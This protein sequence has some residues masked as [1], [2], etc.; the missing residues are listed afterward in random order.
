MPQTITYV[1]YQA[2]SSN[3]MPVNLSPAFMFPVA[4]PAYQ[5]LSWQLVVQD[6]G[7]AIWWGGINADGTLAQ[8]QAPSDFTY[9]GSASCNANLQIQIIANPMPDTKCPCDGSDASGQNSCSA[10]PSSANSV[11]LATGNFIFQKS[12]LS[13][14]G[15]GSLGWSFDLNYKSNFDID[16]LVGKNFAYPQYMHLEFVG[17]ANDSVNQ[18]NVQLVTDQLS[19]A[20]FFN[21]GE[22]NF[23]AQAGSNSSQCSLKVVNQFTAE[24]EYILTASN[25]TVTTFYGFNYYNYLGEEYNY[26]NP[27][28]GQIKSI[29]DRN[30]N[31]MMYAWTNSSSYIDEFGEIVYDGIPLLVSVTDSYGRAI[32]YS[33]YGD[34]GGYLLQQIT[35]YLGRQLNFQYDND[36]RLIAV[37]TPAI[38]RA[39]PGNTFPGG[40]AYV[41]QYDSGNANSAR[42]DD[43]IKIWYPNQTQPYLNIQTRTV[44]VES[45]YTNATPRY[46][47]TY[48]QDI[49]DLDTYGKVLTETLGDP[50][51]GIGGTAAFEYTTCA[52][53]LP[54]NIID[55]SSAGT[56]V[57]RTIHTDRNGNRTIYDF[58]AGWTVSRLEVD[59]NRS[60]S[61]LELSN[62]G[63]VAP[64]PFVTWTKFNSQNQPLVVVYPEGNSVEYTYDGGIIDGLPSP[65]TPMVGLLLKE[66]RLP[67]NSISLP[68]RSGSNGQTMLSK[69]YFYDPIFNR[70]CAMIEERGN[71]IATSGGSNV[72][73][74]PQNLGIAPTDSIRSRYAT[75]YY[76][77]YQKDTLATV[78]NDP[79]LQSL[80]GLSSGEIQTLIGYVNG[81]MTATDGTGGIPIGFQLNLGDING[82][83]TGN[84]ASSGLPSATHLGN[85]VQAVHPSVLL[86]GGATQPRVELFTVNQRGQV[87]T[88]TDPEGNLTVTTRYPEND[89]EGTGNNVSPT[90]ST[91]QYG[92]V[93]EVHKDANPD[94]VMSLVGASG[95]LV[96]FVPGIISRTNTP[97]IYQ[98]LVTRYEGSS[99]CAACAYDPMGNILNETDPRGFTTIYDRN[100]MGE[101]Y[102]VTSPAP[103][104][105]RV[106]T[107]YDANRNVI[108]VDTEDLQ[109][110]YNSSDPT[111]SGYGTFTPSGSGTT[112]HVPMIPGPGGILRPG[113]FSN[114]M[115]YDILDDKTEEDI[116][117]TGSAPANLVTQY[118]YDANQN[119]I[120]LIKPAGNIVEYD[121][122]ERNLKIAERVGYDANNPTISPGAVTIYSYD[123]NK[124]LLNIIGAVD[125]NASGGTAGATSLKAYIRNAFGSGLVLTATGD[126]VLQNAYDGFDRVVIATDAVG[127]V[128][129]STYDPTSTL[130]QKQTQ[131]TV[132]GAT[133]VNR[134][135]SGNVLLAS[136]EMRY[137]EALR[138]YEQQ[139]DVFMAGGSGGYAI[140]HT[141]GGLLA[142]STDNTHTGTV[143]LTSGGSSYVLTRTIYDRSGRVVATLADN[144]AQ[145]SFAYDGAGRQTLSTDPLG[146]TVATQFDGNSNPVRVT[147][148]EVCTIITP[149]VANEMFLSFTWFDCL[150]RPVVV[151]T[152]GADGDLTSNLNLCC[153]W[154]GLPSTLY[155][156]VGYDSRSNKTTVTDPKLN[157]VVS[158]Y[159]GA[160]RLI[161]TQ[162][163]MRMNGDG[164]NA[165]APNHTFLT[166]GGGIIRTEYAYD[167]NSRLVELADDRSALTVYAYDLL[168]RLVTKTLA[169]GS[170]STR[171]Y[172]L[173]NCLAGY[174][175]ENGSVLTYTYDAL[176]R[177]TSQ[178]S[179]PATG[180]VSVGTINY[181][182][183]GLSRNSQYQANSG[184]S[185]VQLAY[186]SIN[187]TLEE[188]QVN[189][190]VSGIVV[191]SQFQSLVATQITYP[192]N[193]TTTNTYDL[194]YRRISV[195][196]AYGPTALDA[197][198]WQFFGPNRIAET[199]YGNGSLIAT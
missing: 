95:D 80:L 70:L 20:V 32:N 83:G 23:S 26:T 41:F 144:T 113:W 74:A 182:Y 61:S 2:I 189:G 161:E 25:G 124:N 11:E 121:Y 131:G 58:N 151:G 17:V 86:V 46:Q 56:I 22:G 29:V 139:Q 174:T 65:Y 120:K 153:P 156:L 34:E 128:A 69:S 159:D 186:D 114:L 133:P 8:G 116:D 191:H 35:D 37:V 78:S 14:V 67:G 104:N 89:P 102:R 193:I 96:D 135:G 12:L 90:L 187:R 134:R 47:I 33:Y 132:G 115:S 19:R 160:S 53:D 21:D 146:N 141:G 155:S 180:V 5:N 91:Q 181:Q 43:L 158:V 122:D 79:N 176:L 38:L 36:S 18:Y 111:S 150:N 42:Q 177:R 184:S 55:S 82:D 145:T 103:Y 154:M 110:Q 183:D 4:N 195:A 60:K 77:D 123:G 54:A 137:D 94:D 178:T 162:Q 118:G 130:I 164:R 73:F 3:G 136:T 13:L 197:V 149:S 107:S 59:L 62:S 48:G 166:A 98:D 88:A 71:P 169:D 9:R 85:Q 168:D 57:S 68:S 101:I 190:S 16:G 81:Q 87:T 31:S 140:T 152:Q 92:L 105:F 119:L 165:P 99:G 143:T 138:L 129:N 179:E 97:G 30:G 142:N 66:T 50:E 10:S 100:E 39:A 126:W 188:Y 40:T 27:A 6:E 196:G 63:G 72:Y 157:V 112:A 84:G 52:D 106:E 76:F 185:I 167:G 51:S 192:N 172:D 64:V 109:V 44:D 194:L 198:S 173:A 45:V 24:E 175:D 108:Q 7:G 148:T 15:I 28:S 75:L 125:H 147:Q 127:G 49:G 163:E 93:R 170:V 199:N 171:V 1:V 117:A